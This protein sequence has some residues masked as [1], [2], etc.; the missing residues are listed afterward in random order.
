[1]TPAG[2]YSKG[3]RPGHG[4]RLSTQQP[5]L[6]LLDDPATRE[7]IGRFEQLAESRGVAPAAL[8]FVWLLNR[9]G[10]TAPI[11]GVTKPS[12]WDAVLASVDV[13]WSD[14]LAGSVDEIFPDP[15]E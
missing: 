8:A 7:R 9:P 10:V 13:P 4:S 14:G 6:G 12:Q 2:R 3:E 1:M 5:A 11:V 15:T